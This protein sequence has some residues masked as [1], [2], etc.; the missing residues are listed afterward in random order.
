MMSDK[1]YE[2][3]LE[4]FTEEQQNEIREHKAM[5]DFAKALLRDITEY[6]AISRLQGKGLD[7]DSIY[8][9]LEKTDLSKGFD[10]TVTLSYQDLLYHIEG[11]FNGA[12]LWTLY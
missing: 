3:K 8:E 7:V 5:Q 1:N 12:R 4:N 10:G 6:V 11:A 9:A 2:E